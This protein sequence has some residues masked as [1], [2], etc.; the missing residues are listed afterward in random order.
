[1][2]NKNSKTFK[3]AQILSFLAKKLKIFKE[4]KLL[5][6]KITYRYNYIYLIFVYNLFYKI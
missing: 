2:I 3:Y 5:E 6:I 4:K 1:M